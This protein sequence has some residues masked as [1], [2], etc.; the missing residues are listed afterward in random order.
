MQ[1]VR[2]G[3]IGDN[4]A[5]SKAPRL[6]ALAGRMRGASRSSSEEGSSPT[7][8][9]SPPSRAPD[10]TSS[11]IIARPGTTTGS[12]SPTPT[13]S[14]RRHG[15]GFLPFDQVEPLVR[16]MGA[17]NTVVFT[18]DG[19]RG[20][21]T[22][23]TGFVTAWRARFE[24][25]RPGTVR[26]CAQPMIGF[27]H[28][29]E[30]TGRRE[31]GRV[32]PRRPRRGGDPARGPRPRPGRAPRGGA[33]GGATG[34]GRATRLQAARR[35]AHR[36]G[37]EDPTSGSSSSSRP[38]PGASSTALRSAWSATME[39]RSHADSCTRRRGPSTRST[40]RSTPASSPTPQQRLRQGKEGRYPVRGARAGGRRARRLRAAA[41]RRSTV[42]GP[43]RAAGLDTLN[44]YE[45][46]FE[47]GLDCTEIFLGGRVDRTRLRHAPVPHARG[48]RPPVSPQPG[49]LARAGLARRCLTV[50]TNH[51]AR[52]LPI[53]TTDLITHDPQ[54]GPAALQS[55]EPP[56][57]RGL[58]VSARGKL[59]KA[60]LRAPCAGKDARAPRK[61]T[62]LVSPPDR[63]EPYT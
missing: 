43:R 40:P 50:R 36:E 39:R 33:Q 62:T 29:G 1:K 47:Q 35:D 25:A 7:T 61:T 45:L 42:G 49:T 16:A 8:C 60:A 21:N 27:S 31:G 15:S 48:L 58:P 63:A 55:R 34:N 9:W 28:A 44:G 52:M 14:G 41:R 23:H 20:F 46:F 24:P 26:R 57:D 10:S 56:W 6:H 17:V 13:R 51:C 54:P 5:A 12:T 18:S 11:S 22:D 4:I 38:A 37:G 2:I 3:L 59:A 53:P 19:P 32:R 30:P